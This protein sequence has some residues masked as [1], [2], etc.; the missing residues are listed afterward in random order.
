MIFYIDRSIY[1]IINHTCFP[2]SP[3]ARIA[4]LFGGWCLMDPPF[5]QIIEEILS[6]KAV[7]KSR[8]E[9][10]LLWNFEHF[11]QNPR[12]GIILANYSRKYALQISSRSCPEIEC[13]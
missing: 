4:S 6:E 11:V 13:F 5:E 3:N 10:D 2:S 12:E 8:E 1:K 7:K 9:I